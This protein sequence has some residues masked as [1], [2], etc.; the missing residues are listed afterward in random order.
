MNINIREWRTDDL[1]KLA[2]AWATFCRDQARS[3]MRLKPNAEQAMTRWLRLRFDDS[4]GF[5][6]IAEQDSVWAGFLVGR[7]DIFESAPPVIEARNLGIID[8]VY[9]PDEVRRQGVAGML[10]RRALAAMKQRNV[11][12]VETIYDLSD[13]ASVQTWS[14]EGFLPWMVHAYRIL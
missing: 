9:I 4:N 7:I 5:G 8:A 10:I 11:T 3:D 2:S 1:P 12:A 13:D 14:S 6:Y